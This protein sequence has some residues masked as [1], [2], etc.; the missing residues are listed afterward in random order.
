MALHDLLADRQADASARVLGPGVQAL[1][2]DENTLCI[3]RL[4][5]DAV[6]A[7]RKQPVGPAPAP[8]GLAVGRVSPLRGRDVLRPNV[9]FG[10]TLAPKLDGVA[11]QV[12]K[13]LYQLRPV[14]H[15]GWQAIVGDLGAALLNGCLKVG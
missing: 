5:T 11:Q 12:L 7:H 14:G 10:G 4:D 6:I 9:D 3:L 15:Q 13:Q 8:S 1:K 2:D